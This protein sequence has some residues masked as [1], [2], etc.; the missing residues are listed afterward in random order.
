M[1]GHIYTYING[2]PQPEKDL[3]KTLTKQRNIK[4]MQT[5]KQISKQADKASMPT[6]KNQK[7]TDREI[8]GT[9]SPYP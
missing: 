9:V 8:S 1:L 3:K 7:P 2:Y 5:D 4:L 6:Y